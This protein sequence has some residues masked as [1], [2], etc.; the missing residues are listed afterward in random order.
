MAT[1]KIRRPYEFSG[2]IRSY[3]IV[4]DGQVVGKVANDSEIELP[5]RAGDHELHIKV[6]WCRSNIVRFSTRDNET[7]A[8][9]CTAQH[10]LLSLYYV[11]FKPRSYLKLKQMA[12][13]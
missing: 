4:L 6:D 3:P 13:A 12:P 1:I 5:V 7:V 8:F 10:P 9:E 2:M 11:V